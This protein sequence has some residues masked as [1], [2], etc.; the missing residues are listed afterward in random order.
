MSS[1]LT[2][3]VLGAKGLQVNFFP[4][5][6]LYE[7]CFEFLVLKGFESIFVCSPCISLLSKEYRTSM[8]YRLLAQRVVIIGIGHA[9]CIAQSMTFVHRHWTVSQAGY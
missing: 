1:Q 6:Q 4:L 9:H 7:K 2:S 5:L 8:A 3:L